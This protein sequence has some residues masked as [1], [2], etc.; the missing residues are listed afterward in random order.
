[1][2]DP[3]RCS[4]SHEGAAAATHPPVVSVRQFC[5]LTGIRQPALRK[6]LRAGSVRGYKLGDGR[7]WLIPWEEALRHAAETAQR[8]AREM[9]L[10][11]DTAECVAAKVTGEAQ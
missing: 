4:S 1:M 8:E 7:A 5:D 6:R 9:H 11:A 3:L 10:A 2:A